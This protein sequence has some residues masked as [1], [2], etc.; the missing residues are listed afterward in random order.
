MSARWIWIATPGRNVMKGNVSVKEIQLGTENTAEVTVHF[1][2]S[3]GLLSSVL[4]GWFEN[5]L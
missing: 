1:N 5:I 4:F 3:C 2:S